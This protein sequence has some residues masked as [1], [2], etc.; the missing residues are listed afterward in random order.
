MKKRYKIGI[1][2]IVCLAL[3][4]CL[5]MFQAYRCF[6]LIC[7]NTGSRKGYTELFFGVKVGQWYQKSMLEDFMREN[8]P[9][10]LK[11]RWTSYAGTGYNCFGMRMLM[12][13]GRPG[14]I[15]R[16]PSDLLDEWVQT[17]EPEEVLELYQ[18]LTSDASEEDKEQRI[19]EI[20]EEAVDRW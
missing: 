8:H 11:H 5:G 17:S 4:Y 20:S 9:D 14:A 6:G 19:Y 12:A 10:L 18:L 3:L 15:K 7:E 2:V 1:W 16:I 13:H